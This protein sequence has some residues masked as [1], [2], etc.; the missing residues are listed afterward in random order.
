ML[1]VGWTEIFLIMVVAILVVGPDEIPAL[2]VT[3]GRIV[4]RFQYIKYA[5]SQQFE[6]LMRE[7]DMDDLRN[8]VNFEAKNL[9]PKSEND[10]FDEAQADEEM[11]DK[12]SHSDLTQDALVR[13]S[14]SDG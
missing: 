14:Q 4:R 7:A 2:M 13:G 5:F 6:D 11:T 1:E 12:E 9:S 8:S 3:F 10:Q